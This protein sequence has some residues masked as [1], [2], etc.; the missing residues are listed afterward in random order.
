MELPEPEDHQRHGIN[1]TMSTSALDLNDLWVRYFSVSGVAD[2]FEIDAYLN[3]CLS[4]PFLERDKLAAATNEF[5]DDE[6]SSGLRIP[7]SHQL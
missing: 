5:L 6:S 7:Y 2:V 1:Y 4:L 3:N